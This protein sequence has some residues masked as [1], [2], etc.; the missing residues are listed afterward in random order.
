MESAGDESLDLE[1]CFRQATEF[2]INGQYDEAMAKFRLILEQDANHARAR[3]GLALCCNFTGLF[4]ESI[5]E[6]LKAIDSDPQ[7]AEAHL[8][9]GKAYCM[10]GQY[11]EAREEFNLVLKLAP[12][13]D[14]VHAE[15]VK[16]LSYFPSE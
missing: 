5:E 8:Q 14:P 4:E 1:E 15:A 10:L 12:A 7:W 2:K 11:D 9:L 6:M 16:Q 13:D 3:L